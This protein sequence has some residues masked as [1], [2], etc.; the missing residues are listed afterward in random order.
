MY[1]ASHVMFHYR[2]FPIG[3]L[4]SHPSRSVALYLGRALR[5]QMQQRKNDRHCITFHLVAIMICS[6]MLSYSRTL[7]T[8]SKQGKQ[9][10]PSPSY[11]HP[12]I[13]QI[14][15]VCGRIDGSALL[16]SLCCCFLLW[17]RGSPDMS[18]TTLRTQ[19]NH[20]LQ[21]RTSPARPRAPLRA[22][23]L[24]RL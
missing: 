11:N 10:Y 14:C 3:S 2:L 19:F 12:N 7:Q 21:V 4:I 6:P 16:V 24:L 17:L 18:L 20:G 23:M 22:R 5:T 15:V 13:L 8:F 1:V 9:S